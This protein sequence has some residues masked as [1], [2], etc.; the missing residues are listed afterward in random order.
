MNIKNTLADTVMEY[1]CRILL[2]GTLIYLIVR[3]NTIPDQIPIHYNAA[4]DID[5]WGGK[6]MVWLLVVISWG[7]YLGITF[8]GRFPELWNTGVKITKKNKEKVYRLIKYLIGTSK[9]IL[10]SVFTLLIVFST[11]AKP[12]PLWF[13]GIYLTILIADMVFWLVRIFMERK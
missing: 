5:G 1:I 11:L 13:A 3:W 12:L 6:G 8:V 7:L 10:I 2:I 4:G 9:L